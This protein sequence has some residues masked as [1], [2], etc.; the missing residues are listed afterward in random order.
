MKNS[1]AKIHNKKERI[2]GRMQEAAGELTG[3]QQLE[4]KGKLRVINADVK[5]K[6]DVKEK[7][8]DIKENVAKKVNDTID[9]KHK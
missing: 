9:K 2:E 6:M 8:H 3:N 4:L 7:V 5:S 1:N